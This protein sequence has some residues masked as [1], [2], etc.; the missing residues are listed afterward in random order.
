MVG[1]VICVSEG[2]RKLLTYIAKQ[3][4][5][6]RS[7]YI[8]QKAIIAARETYKG[9]RQEVPNNTQNSP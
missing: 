4:G 3:Q 9:L 7:S 2:E 5:I 1:I 8:K 6:S